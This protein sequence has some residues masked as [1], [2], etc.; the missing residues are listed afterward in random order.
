MPPKAKRYSASAKPATQLDRSA[1]NKVGPALNGVV[2]REAGK[3]EGYKYSDAMTGA[4]L[5]WD[6][7]TLNEFLTKPKD[8]VPGTKM[9]FGG[10]KKDDQRADLIAYL[11]TFKADGSN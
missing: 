3:A 11:K 6:E 5:T 10:L 9:I 4:G 1:K 2:G 8:K 7:A